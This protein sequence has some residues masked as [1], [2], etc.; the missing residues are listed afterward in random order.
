LY[1]S[2]LICKG[3]GYP[4]WYPEPDSSG[5]A[6]YAE[7][8][9]QPGDVGILSDIGGFNYLFNIYR[10]A[11]HAVN[12]GGV[13]PGFQPLHSKH[14]TSQQIIGNCYGHNI[15]SAN[16]DCTEIS[17]G[18]SFEF[19]TTKD[20]AAILCL[21]NSATKYENLNK[22]AIKD[23]ATANGAAWYN[24]VNSSEYLGREAPNGSLYVVTGCDKTDSWGT[25]AVGKP[26]QSREVSISF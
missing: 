25:A 14:S 4:F 9:V 16:V 24:Y 6:V 2:H 17:A 8:G 18:A 26:S 11:D 19:R 22:R 3:H 12:I 7:Q 10:D 5:S 15:T 23:Y 13:P 20:S 21:P 1:I